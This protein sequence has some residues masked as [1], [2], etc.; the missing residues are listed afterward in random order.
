M[1][2]RPC[3]RTGQGFAPD[4]SRTYPAGRKAGLVA[5][6]LSIV[7]LT[8]CGRPQAAALSTPQVRPLATRTGPDASASGFVVSTDGDI[9]TNRH[10]VN[11]CDSVG[12]RTD[13]STTTRARI[14]ASE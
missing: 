12:V 2:L 6:V 9:V 10:V 13:T 5:I 11:R 3:P 1:T 8:A 7:A 4:A 14:V